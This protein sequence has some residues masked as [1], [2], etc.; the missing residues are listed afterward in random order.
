MQHVWSGETIELLSHQYFDSCWPSI[1]WRE[2]P[3][4]CNPKTY[5]DNNVYLRIHAN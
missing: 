5:G 3:L 2:V 1:G 4:K